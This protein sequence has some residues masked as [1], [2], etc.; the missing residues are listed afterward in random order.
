[1]PTDRRALRRRKQ[2]HFTS[3][4]GGTSMQADRKSLRIFCISFIFA[5]LLPGSVAAIDGNHD[6]RVLSN[7]ADLISG[8]DALV[9]LIVPPGIIQA[10]Q[11]GNQKIKA[12]LD[13]KPLSDD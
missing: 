4:P 3:G 7:R 12:S 6:I 13:S 9:E 8:G 11:N 2:Q 1:M 5:A 10:M